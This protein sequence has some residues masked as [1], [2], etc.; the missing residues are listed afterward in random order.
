VLATDE[1]GDPVTDVD[2]TPDNDPNNDG[3]VT[4]NA[5]GNEN[6]DEDDHDPAEVLIDDPV[7]DLALV[8]RLGAGQPSLIGIG[9]LVTYNITVT[10]QGDAAASNI[11]IVDYLPA[12][13]TL[14]DGSWAAGANMDVAVR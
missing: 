11:T 7:Y 3:P 8:K 4:D 1:N 9:A 12:C 2:S 10:N 5:T 14:A 13:M 6:G